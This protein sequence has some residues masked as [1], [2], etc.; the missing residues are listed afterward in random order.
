MRIIILILLLNLIINTL[1]RT[2]FPPVKPKQ[3]PATPKP[4]PVLHNVNALPILQDVLT[5]LDFI[6]Y[7]KEFVKLGYAETR[8]LLRMTS[9]DF[10]LLMLETNMTE[11]DIAK[12][13]VKIEELLAIATIPQPSK[14]RPDL[15]QRSKLNYGRMYI[16]GFVQ[17]FEFLLGT[18]GTTPRL[19]LYEIVLANP[20]D[21]CLPHS[22]NNSS[23]TDKIYVVKRGNC[24]FMTKATLAAYANASAIVFV[25]NQDRVESFASGYGIDPSIKLPQV[26]FL[27]KIVVATVANSTWPKLDYAFNHF[28][29]KLFAHIVP[30]KCGTGGSCYPL[31]DE[32][33][34][35]LPEV[36]WG[37]LTVTM[38]TNVQTFDF[39]ASTFGGLLPNRDFII[40]KADP[41]EACEEMSADLKKAIN[42]ISSTTQVA[43]IVSRGTCKF[44]VK[45]SYIQE[46]GARLMIVTDPVDN[47]LQRVGGMA[48]EI[49]YI[50]IPSILV[51]KPCAD[52]LQNSAKSALEFF[53]DTD[54]SSISNNL[55]GKL[56]LGKDTHGADEWIDVAYTDWAEDNDQ[57]LLQI[58]GLIKKYNDSDR[59]EI[60]SWLQRQAALL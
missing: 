25:N 26:E 28:K 34:Q 58:E 35:I 2:R 16:S 38:N 12:L 14:E 60:V 30:L 47:C 13:K 37:T 48:P 46:S 9:M 4:K 32:E 24:T 36:S 1:A 11:D 18:F 5:E 42:A 45:A 3:E 40:I 20:D 49:G 22:D 54:G 55:M 21:G 17:S 51:T 29:E 57:K 53:M 33:K 27:N 10:R 31:V 6:K 44:D 23:L 52:F 15:E 41:F 39:L 8:L 43:I 50:G 19:G 56:D 7:I 59:K